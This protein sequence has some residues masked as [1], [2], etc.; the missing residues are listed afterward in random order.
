MN[1]QTFNSFFDTFQKEI[2]DFADK[3]GGIRDNARFITRRRSPATVELRVAYNGFKIGFFYHAGGGHGAKSVVSC[4]FYKTGDTDG[5]GFLANEVMNEIDDGDFS[6]YVFSH[7][8]DEEQ[9][10]L[11][12]GCLCKKLGAKLEAIGGFFADDTRYLPFRQ[13]IKENINELFGRDAFLQAEGLGEDGKSF[14]LRV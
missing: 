13:T 12:T 8:Y 5:P 14:L 11:A 9:I 6:R 2:S 10:K 4:I 1:Q 3:S 7:L